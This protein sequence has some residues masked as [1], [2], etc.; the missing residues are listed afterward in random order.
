MEEYKQAL[1]AKIEELKDQ[2]SPLAKSRLVVLLRLLG[3]LQN[4]EAKA[5]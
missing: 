5:A 2:K 4:E 3:E 1:I